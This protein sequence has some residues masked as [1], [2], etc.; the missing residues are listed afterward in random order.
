[1]RNIWNFLMPWQE[2]NE[3]DN[4]VGASFYIKGLDGLSQVEKKNFYAI[5]FIPGAQVTLKHVLIGSNTLILEVASSTVAVDLSLW[6][7]L[8]LTHLVIQQ[9]AVDP[10]SKKEMS[11]FC[12]DVKSPVMVA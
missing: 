6:S 2:K 1:M 4:L 12:N 7:N 11:T 10:S 5:G 9:D 8:R 3:L